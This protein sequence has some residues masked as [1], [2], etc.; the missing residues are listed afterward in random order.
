MTGLFAH[1]AHLVIFLHVLSA[2]IWVGGMIAVRGVVHPALQ[3]IES[4][5]VRLGKT[6]EVTGRLFHLAIPFIVLILLTAIVMVVAVDGHRGEL[7]G[8]FI[9]KEAIWTIMSL[10][11]TYMYFL[12][13]RAWRLFRAG[14]IPGA[15]D[16]VRL[17][18]NLLLPINIVLGVIALWLGITLRGI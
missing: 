8:I 4:P 6:L 5:E 1:Y 3:G 7:G 2:V 18:P 11:F 16:R 12:R 9:F 14:N 10:N 13:R 15:K 17:L